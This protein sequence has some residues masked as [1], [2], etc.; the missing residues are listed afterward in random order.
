MNWPFKIIKTSDFNKTVLTLA[1]ALSEKIIEEK[2]ESIEDEVS[3]RVNKI[4]TDA[5]F[6]DD[7]RNGTDVFLDIEARGY[8][9]FSIERTQHGESDEKTVV[10]YF[11][12]DH[13]G[14]HVREWKLY[15]SRKHHNQLVQEFKLRKGTNIKL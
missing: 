12:E 3:Q 2:T 7:L 8:E 1:T 15:I 10:G 11:W 6:I 9:V 13:E 14:R 5:E 4:I